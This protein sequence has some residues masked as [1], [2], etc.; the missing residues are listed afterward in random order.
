MNV[1]GDVF[2][3]IEQRLKKGE[4]VSRARNGVSHNERKKWNLGVNQQ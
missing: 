3:D 4:K 2:P 1:E